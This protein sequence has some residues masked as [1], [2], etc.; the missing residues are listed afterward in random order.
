M[1][2]RAFFVLTSTIA[3]L[4][5]FTSLFFVLPKTNC[6]DELDPQVEELTNRATAGQLDAITTLYERAK[7]A[8]V[9]PNQEYWALEGALRGDRALRLAYIEMF[10]T[11]IDPDRQQRLLTIIKERSAM[12]GTPC[13]LESLEMSSPIN[14]VCKLQKMRADSLGVTMSP[15]APR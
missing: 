1:K 6:C 12:P 15:R 3:V 2:S 7:K 8:G 5:L 9:E 10:K 13:L 4:A 11:R 14:S